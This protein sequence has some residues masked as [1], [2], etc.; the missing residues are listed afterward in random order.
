[1]TVPLLSHAK[2]LLPARVSS[3]RE[4]IYGEI[5]SAVDGLSYLSLSKKAR[6]TV[7]AP[8]NFHRPIHFKKKTSIGAFTYLNDGF[9]D[10]CSHIGRYCALGQ[11]LRIGEPNHPID[12]LSTANF[13]YNAKEFGWHASANDYEALDPKIRGK[14]FAGDAASIGNDVWIGARV[15]ILRGV[16]VGDGAIIAAGAVVNK[17]V[18]PY[19]IVGGLPARVLRYRFDEDTIA[20][21]LRLQWWRYSPNQLSGINFSNIAEAVQQ[22]QTAERSGVRPY[23]PAPVAIVAADL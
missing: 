14:H 13:Q 2:R 3:K 19:A 7:E 11:D 8:V 12:W 23:A 15:T 5:L 21:L 20:K 10:H 1:M 9:I 17:D 16:K 22:V 6:L 18:P 4:T